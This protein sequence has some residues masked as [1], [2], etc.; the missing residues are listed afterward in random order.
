LETQKDGATTTLTQPEPDN[1]R[2]TAPQR[3]RGRR[4]PLL[5]VLVSLITV[6]VV[7]LVLVGV[8][9]FRPMRARSLLALN[10]VEAQNLEQQ[11][12]SE[13]WSGRYAAAV[14]DF[15]HACAL[16]HA[17]ACMNLGRMF[18]GSAG[19]SVDND[20]AARAYQRACRA[21]LDDGCVVVARDYVSG[22]GLPVDAHKADVLYQK[23][24][25]HGNVAGCDGLAD[26][27]ENGNGVAQDLSR[28]KQLLQ[29][30]CRLGYQA[31]CD[32]LQQPK[33]Q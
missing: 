23:T 24:C 20:R 19:I 25:E 16:G 28:A 2:P 33:F 17:D 15:D 29:K 12:M 1:S 9:V 11:A 18:S 13:Q 14:A 4:S 7:L 30:A 8:L 27:Y 21:G 3:V 6:F 5:A 10:S 22:S 31:S 26:L 32:R